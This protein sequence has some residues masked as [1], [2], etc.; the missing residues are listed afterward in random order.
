MRQGHRLVLLGVILSIYV[1]LRVYGVFTFMNEY[2]DYDEGTYLL[3]ARLI[4][5]GYLPYRDIFAVHPPLYY[6]LLAG[7]QRVLGDNYVGG[8]ILSV[9]FGFLSIVTAYL[10]GKDIRDWKLGIL[11]SVFLTLDPLL[12]QINP[13]VFH[14]SSIEFFTLLSLYYFVK[15][16][17][18]DMEKYAYL[19]LFW[20]G[21]GST[22]K[23]TI[24]PYSLALYLIILFMKNPHILRY[25]SKAASVVFNKKQI[26]ILATTYLL[27]VLIVMVSLILWPSWYVRKV[28]V[29]PGIHRITYWDHII[30]IM[31]LILIWATLTLKV[32]K[33]SYLSFFKHMILYVLN[34]LK[35]ALLLALAFLIPKIVIEGILGFFVSSD[36][37]SQTYLLQGGRNF[38]IINFFIFASDRFQDIYKN[39]LESWMFILPIVLVLLLVLAI[40]TFS[41]HVSLSPIMDYV[42]ALLLTTAVMYFF[43][44]PSIISSR[45]ILPILL[46]SYIVLADI[47]YNLPRLLQKI[48][49][50]T[51]V[52]FVILL[53]L[54][55]D[56]GIV[57]Q[58]PHGNLKFIYA[59]HT[60]SLRGGL[61]QYIHVENI[62]IGKTYSLNPM[63]TYYFNADT[64][65]YY[66]DAFGLLLLKDTNSSSLFH[67]LETEG[68]QY[69]IIST[70][71]YYRWYN[72]EFRNSLHRF[73]DLIR[74]SSILIYGESYNNGDI[75]ELYF[76]SPNNT[77]S[78]S[79]YISTYNGT[80]NIWFN[81][82]RILQL[83]AES[84][85]ATFDFRARIQYNPATSQYF[86]TQYS[87]K[88]STFATSFL[89]YLENNTIQFSNVSLRIVLDFSCEIT[90]F[91]RNKYLR[92]GEETN[93]NL[94]V[95][96]GEHSLKITGIGI[97]VQKVSKTK[98]K[99]TGNKFEIQFIS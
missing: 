48:H 43:I 14:E 89:V 46:L 94:R 42:I 70:W 12:I 47:I 21:I 22:S 4:N 80:V 41:K 10:I 3:I 51:I 98:L 29:V 88:P 96:C 83:Y 54:I 65:P 9:V 5:Q 84:D 92:T 24:L 55:S 1:I 45:F 25:F 62:S 49:V 79:L 69:F 8:R 36:Y 99:I 6:Y 44:S 90:A 52:Y 7:W 85:N 50:Q 34:D 73:I 74:K 26:L 60:K 23:F 56:F 66:I 71:A 37:V 28:I 72:K 64:V 31:T 39:T 53:L 16:V 58:Y 75:L 78:K 82:T 35:R 91:A 81:Q 86:V 2:Y 68:V 11:F 13:L 38:P 61:D 87:T 59:T 67:I 77:H 97:T 30:P 27:M 20:V 18:W 95:Y 40:W 17:K 63:N 33:I 57:Y 76:Y 93:G 32:F 15:Y 19:S